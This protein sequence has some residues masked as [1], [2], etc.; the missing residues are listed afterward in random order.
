MLF[1]IT[2]I[3]MSLLVWT[4]IIAQF[5][6]YKELKEGQYWELQMMVI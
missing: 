5:E 1:I 4:F 2:L 6:A 3:I